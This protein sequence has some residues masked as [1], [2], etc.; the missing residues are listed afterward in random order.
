MRKAQTLLIVEDDRFLADAYQQFFANMGVSIVVLTDGAKVVE[1]ALKLQPSVILL[2]ILLPIKDGFTILHELKHLEKTKNI[3]VVV[4]SNLG[5][6]EEIAK[7]KNLGA[8]DYIVKSE[9][10]L[11]EITS[12]LKKYL[13]S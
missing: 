11:T 5:Q 1:Q 9:T 4:A 10:S 2:D 3:P 8:A 6:P 13:Q 12:I 7:G